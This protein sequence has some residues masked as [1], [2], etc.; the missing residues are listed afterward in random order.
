MANGD[1][2]ISSPSVNISSNSGQIL[3]TDPLRSSWWN[4]REK[5]MI[6]LN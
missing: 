1:I 3:Q 2:Q 6:R 4:G 5:A